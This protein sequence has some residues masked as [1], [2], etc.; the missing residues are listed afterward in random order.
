MNPDTIGREIKLSK[1]PTLTTPN[2]N[3]INP[4]RKAKHDAY[5]ARVA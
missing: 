3:M 1:K 5:I 4:I 2:V